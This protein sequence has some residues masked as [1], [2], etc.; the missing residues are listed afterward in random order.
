VHICT[1]GNGITYVCLCSPLLPLLHPPSNSPPPP[2]ALALQ[3]FE[4]GLGGEPWN[5]AHGGYTFCGLAAAMLAGKEHALDLGRL[6][7]WTVKRQVCFSI[8]LAGGAGACLRQVFHWL[9]VPAEI[10][11]CPPFPSH[12]SPPLTSRLFSQGSI[13]GGFNGRTNKLV[14]GCY[15]FWQGGTFP[16]LMQALMQGPRGSNRGGGDKGLMLAAGAIQPQAFRSSRAESGGSATQGPAPVA[17]ASN[18][19]VLEVLAGLDAKPPAAVAAARVE[20]AEA[21]LEAAVEAS[22][23]AEEQ[24]TRA[25]QVHAANVEELR[26]AAAAALESA[27]AVQ[28]VRRAMACWCRNVS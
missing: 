17:T 23:A 9:F 20:Q 1:A 12:P 18:A 6:L 22:I 4:G 24:Y 13:E 25:G 26:R 7:H 27:Q 10:Q 5:E 11:K 19:E 21:L 14:D 2:P 28:E 8:F 16:L 15:S 3:S